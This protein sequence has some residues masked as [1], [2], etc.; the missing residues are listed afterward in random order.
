[1]RAEAV[2]DALW[3]RLSEIIAHTTGLHFPP[4]RRADLQR[5]LITAAAELGFENVAACADWLASS[6]PT[7]EQL[8]TLA[9]HLTIG[10]TYFFRERKTFDALQTQVLPQ[11]LRARTSERRL[12]VWS[13][14]C[15][16]GEEPYSLAIL[17]RELMPDWD[18]WRVTIL[19]TDINERF[20]QKAAAGIYGEWS[21]R[22]TPADFRER[23][24]DRTREGRYALIPQIR[25]AVTF[26]QLNLAEDGFPSL[27]TDTNAMDLILCRNV[28]IYFTPAQARGLVEKLRQALVPDGWLAVSPSECSQ[29]LFNRFATEN[30]PGAILYRN[31][32][33]PAMP[34]PAPWMPS[35]RMHTTHQLYAPVA[36][37]PSPPP[38]VDSEPLA[39][40]VL[41]ITSPQQPASDPGAATRTLANQGRLIEARAASERWIEA[42]KLDPAARYLHAMIAQELG[43]PESAR[44]SLQRA[45]YLSPRFALAHFALGNLSRN[46]GRARESARHFENALRLLHDL[47]PGEL[48]PESDGLTAGRLAEIIAA[49]PALPRDAA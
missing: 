18:A 28:L 21:F 42:D 35:S 39:A 36:Q 9:S 38:E 11:L 6:S 37:Q 14:A 4:E 12:R 43:D 16:T 1:M 25:D 17:L 20:L 19:A 49:L 32:D 45:I 10:E 23:Y 46:E 30:F 7:P 5:G 34:Q 3:P 47:A 44:I 29:A 48:L 27:A 15:A 22:D 2:P 31:G 24:F 13:A 41:E 8:R 33:G 26:M 40:S